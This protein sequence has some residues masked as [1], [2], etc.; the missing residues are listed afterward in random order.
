MKFKNE[1]ERLEKLYSYNILDTV[2]DAQFDEI[3]KLAARL[4]DAEI[5]L[6]T[7][8]DK[9]RQWFKS[10]HGIDLQETPREHSFCAHTILQE[11]FFEIE[12]ARKD[13]R[14]SG[15]PLVTGK[16]H[17]V[18]YAGHPLISEDGYPLGALCVIHHQPQ[19]LNDLQRHS[20]EVLTKQV[21]ARLELKKK[22]IEVEK[23]AKKIQ[24]QSLF[25]EE[26]QSQAIENAKMVGLGKMAGGVAHEI[27]NP[28]GVISLANG[29]IQA[30]LDKPEIDKSV[31]SNSTEK[32]A[33]TIQ[34][35]SK[36]V[37]GLKSISRN[38][39]KDPKQKAKLNDIIE[40]ALTTCS[41]HM[42]SNSIDVVVE[43]DLDQSMLCRSG[44]ISQVILNLLSNAS[45]AVKDLE[46]KWVRIEISNATDLLI[47]SVIDSGK[48]IPE[49]IANK[50][51]DPFYTTKPVGLGTGLGLSISRSIIEDHDGRL[52]I[53][54]QHPNTKFDLVFNQIT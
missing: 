43:G 3:T 11:D 22:I 9:D 34:R 25:M 50:I 44:E 4:C 36:I 33:A 29:R 41:E 37:R 18:H 6:V 14:F 45:D 15:N 2:D 30:E 26:V 24:N 38:A 49:E 8:V 54:R 47:I 39:N 23:A 52:L 21:M 1:E 42:K 35:I 17:I 27:N 5:S 28:L 20:L 16:P 32:I 53:D 31:I 40:D 51:M 13:S 10:H 48:G 19:R 46:E 12:D 7:L